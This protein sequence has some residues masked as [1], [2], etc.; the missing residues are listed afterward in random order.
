MRKQGLF[1][2]GLLFTVFVMAAVCNAAGDTRDLRSM[3]LAANN[4]YLALYVDVN[5]TEIAVIDRFLDKD[6]IRIHQIERFRNS[7]ARH[8]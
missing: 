6:G 1:L 2:F 8:G 5:T 7:G 3:Q 4:E